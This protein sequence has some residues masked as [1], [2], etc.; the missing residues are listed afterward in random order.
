MELTDEPPAQKLPTDETLQH[1]RAQLEERAVADGD[2]RVACKDTGISPEP[3][4]EALFDS[5]EDA[6]WASRTAS[7]YRATLRRLDPAVPSYDLV[8]SERECGSMECATVRELTDQRRANGLPQA[9]S[10]ITL[11]GDRDEEWLCIEN[12]AVVHLAGPESLLDDELVS[13]QLQ[14]KLSPTAEHESGSHD[15]SE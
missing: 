9:Q 5:Y 7:R 11:A 8:V 10:T 3:V 1:L 2:F 4:A 14:A 15:R 12:G 6:E 13:R